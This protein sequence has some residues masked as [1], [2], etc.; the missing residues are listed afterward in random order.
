[1]LSHSISMGI[2]LYIDLVVNVYIILS[3]L[4]TIDTGIFLYHT[5]LVGIPLESSRILYNRLFLF[6]IGT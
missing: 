2:V 5:Y 1:M 6:G 4:S 3:L